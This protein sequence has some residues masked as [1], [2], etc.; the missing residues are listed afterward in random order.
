M[1]LSLISG[2]TMPEAA[3]I[4]NLV[5]SITVQQLAT[6]GV[7]RPEELLPGWRCGDVSIRCECAIAGVRDI[8]IQRGTDT[9]YSNKETIMR[10]LMIGLVVMLLAAS[11]E[12]AVQTKT[13][14]YK[15]GDLECKGFLAWDDAV[16]GKRPGVLVVHEWWGLDEYARSRAAQLAKLGYVAFACDMYGDGKVAEHPDDARKMASVVRM[17]VET[18]AQASPSLVGRFESSAAVRQ[19]Q[20]G[21]DRLLLRRFDRIATGLHG[22]RSQG[23]RDVS[24]DAAGS[25]GGRSQV[26]EGSRADLPRRSGHVHS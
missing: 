1:V 20:V 24:C 17:N 19:R 3:L 16:E 5:A 8:L 26:A 18:W 10:Q 2:A 13:V 12:A 14:S 21:G 15:H 11:A 22:G 7:A 6:T 4:G 25:D 23:G 9:P